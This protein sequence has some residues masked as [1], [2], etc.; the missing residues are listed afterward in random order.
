MVIKKIFK[1]ETAH[2]V[3]NAYS[4]RCKYNIHG[5]S[6][7]WII[8][9]E[10]PIDEKTGMIIDFKQLNPI[11]KYIDQFDHTTVLWKKE[12]KYIKDFFL[13]N[14]KRVII[15]EQNPTAENMARLIYGFVSKWLITF[16]WD[17]T[18]PYYDRLSKFKV[19]LVEVWETETGCGV[20]NNYDCVKDKITKSKIE[21]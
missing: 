17:P 15:M 21:E 11:K 6:Y 3:R 13:K 18:T 19:N 9:I 14:F 12:K 8:H 7:K 10:G 20:A 1:T 2:I 16:S 4:N 5:H